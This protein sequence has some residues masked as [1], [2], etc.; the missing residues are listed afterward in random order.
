M[1]RAQLGVLLTAI[2]ATVINDALPSRLAH[3]DPLITIQIV[4]NGPAAE[5]VFSRA[6]SICFG[7]VEIAGF[8]QRSIK[9]GATRPGPM[10]A[11][12]IH[13]AAFRG[14]MRIHRSPALGVGGSCDYGNESNTSSILAGQIVSLSL[15]AS[16][17]YQ[18]GAPVT[19]VVHQGSLRARLRRSTDNLAP[20]DRGTLTFLGGDVELENPTEQWVVNPASIKGTLRV[21]P[22]KARLSKAA[23][24]LPG[25]ATPASVTLESRAPVAFDVDTDTAQPSLVEG[26]MSGRGAVMRNAEHPEDLVLPRLTLRTG[27]LAWARTELVARKGLQ[28]I[29][30]RDL[31]I[32]AATASYDREITA[33]MELVGPMQVG[34]LEAGKVA[35]GNALTLS[36]VTLRGIAVQVRNL[37]VSAPDGR[38]IATIGA[39]LA[40]GEL[41]DAHV[42]GKL[43]S[44]TVSE[45]KSLP[46]GLAIGGM[47]ASFDTRTLRPTFSGDLTVRVLPIGALSLRDLTARWTFE[48]VDPWTF[49]FGVKTGSGQLSVYRD[50]SRSEEL[51]RAAV[52]RFSIEGT[53]N[54]LPPPGGV[55]LRIEPDK[56][57]LGLDRI[58]ALRPAVLGGRLVFPTGTLKAVNREAIVATGDAASGSLQLQTPS[59]RLERVALTLDPDRPP[60]P[61]S[62]QLDGSNVTVSLAIQQGGLQLLDADLHA[63]AFEVAPDAPTELR[64]AGVRVTVRRMTID[65]LQVRYARGAGEFKLQT[66]SLDALSFAREGEPYVAGRVT[67]PIALAS[68][69]GDLV[70]S[71]AALA[72]QQTSMS[73]AVIE[74]ADLSYRA[75]DSFQMSAASARIELQNAS[76]DQISCRLRLERG[77]AR[78]AGSLTGEVTVTSADLELETHG[79]T[80]TGSGTVAIGPAVA[81]V[82]A[83][84]PLEICHSQ[85]PL[86]VNV[87]TAG[88]SGRVAIDN[89]GLR[90]QIEMPTLGARVSLP[91]AFACRWGV[92]LLDIPEVRIPY[93]YPCSVIPLKFCQGW[94]AIVPHISIDVEMVLRILQLTAAARVTN[95]VI[96]AAGANGFAPCGGHLDSIAPPGP[97]DILFLISPQLPGGLPMD[98]LMAPL[99][100]VVGALES[101]LAQLLGD[102]AALLNSAGLGRQWSIFGHC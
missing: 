3:A 96:R 77:T 16:I 23:L 89:Q 56:L 12:E 21:K 37:R 42:Y 73:S 85:L 78:L 57:E 44:G 102:V 51:Y 91:R 87:G 97:G 52:A 74:L 64:A 50:P 27:A 8:P 88:G 71:R 80:H 25:I 92:H 18:H 20:L 17:V 82:E 31:T 6:T 4:P 66:V 1:R 100:L 26:T 34:A 30:L 2:G 61:T 10:T 72:L 9:A 48:Y 38:A 59:V 33:T 47:E 95:T 7:N 35:H 36:D 53:A 32:R 63:T 94:A 22:S 98:I 93:W 69:R 5:D 19:I 62:A 86:V 28:T 67:T 49:S 54:L 40:L 68:L 75:P 83:T 81:S 29:A 39:N 15:K 13:M 58:A 24:I 60:V 45:L 84:V 46:D 14:V 65:H 70:P 101:A 11:V 43:G 76:P 79:G 99:H 90:L 55:A 41:S